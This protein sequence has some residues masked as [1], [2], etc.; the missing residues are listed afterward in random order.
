MDINEVFEST[1]KVGCPITSLK[2][3]EAGCRIDY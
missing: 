2:L 1:D 3:K